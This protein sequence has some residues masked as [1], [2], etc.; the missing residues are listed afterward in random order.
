M[1]PQKLSQLDPKLR[2]AYQRVMGT[3]VPEPQA[4]PAP[5]AQSF[6][7]AGGGPASTPAFNTT[8]TAPVVPTEQPS[9]VSPA[10][11]AVTTTQPII[12][13]QTQSVPMADPNA[14]QTNPNFTQMNSGLAAAPTTN[15]SNFA[16]PTPQTQAGVLKKKNPMMPVLFA[17]AGLVFIVIYTL[18]WAK[19]F[20]L[21]LPFL[22]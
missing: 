4:P 9:V 7:S 13:P 5:K 22:P 6:P 19:I 11:E 10:P 20:N 14:P 3:A 21:K 1:D 15:Y 2:D 12:N 17:I 18:F 8:S 16:A